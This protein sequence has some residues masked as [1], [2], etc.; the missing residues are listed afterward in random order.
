MHCGR[1]RLHFPQ[2]WLCSC[3]GDQVLSYHCNYNTSSVIM[4]NQRHWQQQCTQVIPVGG[5]LRHNLLHAHHRFHQRHH[6]H[7]HCLLKHHHWPLNFF[8]GFSTRKLIPTKFTS[9]QFPFAVLMP[10]HRPVEIQVYYANAPP[11]PP[12]WHHWNLRLFSLASLIVLTVGIFN[13]I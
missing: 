10:S 3:A 12:Q 11:H 13:C 6:G 9:T 4:T 5:R 1:A 7:H 8:I 2:F